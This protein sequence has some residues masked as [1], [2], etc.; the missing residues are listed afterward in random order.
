MLATLILFAFV[1]DQ[2]KPATVT[3]AEKK[4]FIELLKKL[5]TRGEFFTSEG[6]KKAG[7]FLRVLL[8]LNEKDIDENYLFA[9]GALCRG[10]CDQKEHREYA[11]KHFG[12][13]S[14][15]VLKMMWGSMLFKDK[16]D[17]SEIVKYL[18]ACVESKEQSQMLASMCGPGFEDFKE[19]VIR[20][21]VVGKSMKVE[22][23]KTHT[24]QAFPEFGGGQSYR[25]R[26]LVFA[27]GGL[28]Y[29][30][31]PNEKKQCGELIT[32]D[33]AKGK[34]SSR[35]IP[36]P[37]GFKPKFDFQSYFEG[38]IL[39]VNTNGD[40][41][42]SWM[43]EGNGDH[44]FALLKKG[45][46]DFQVSRVASN[47]MGSLVVSSPDGHW[48]VIQKE[49]GYF[50]IHRVDQNLKL[51]EIGKIRRNQLSYVSDARFISK[52]TLH[53][54]TRSEE[55]RH[56]SLRSIDFEMKE[57]KVLHNRELLQ[58]DQFNDFGEATFLQLQ[59]STL[60]GL[61]SIESRQMDTEANGKKRDKPNGIYYQAE[62]D[63]TIL[64]VGD[65]KHFR[66]VAMGDRIVVCYTR[67]NAPNNACFCVIHQ[68]VIGP[69]T[70]LTIAKGR[71][72]DLWSEYMVLHAE[73]DRIWFV[74]TISPNT[75]HELKL[76]DMTKP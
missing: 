17:S 45:A 25:N 57:R 18:R 51:V 46:A 21:S 1:F 26:D 58:A 30:V 61:W 76:V 63:T 5:P 47:L 50:V 37:A 4:E 23:V 54:I 31:R 74:N 70:E 75:L 8:A 72:H 40:L 32:Y 42:G 36:Q 16:E 44:G 39:S 59:D 2:P 22:L 55:K 10:L 15:P 49:L 62:S 64:K 71:E 66:A 19:A 52:D 35:F 9:L 56:L 6:V 33:I 7:P 43:I 12:T 38:A 60:Y 69:V 13:I 24:I 67:E 3:D 11:V 68:G 29:A 65:G 34:T 41:L 48:Y 73:G 28:I 20:A 27:Q 14:H 53:L